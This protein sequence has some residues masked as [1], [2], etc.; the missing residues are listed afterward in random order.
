M[1]V[2]NLNAKVGS[3]NI[4]FGHVIEGRGVGERNIS[5]VG[6]IDLYSFDPNVVGCIVPEGKTYQKF[7]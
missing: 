4:L 3:N 6:F 2:F 5:G 7:N 1:V